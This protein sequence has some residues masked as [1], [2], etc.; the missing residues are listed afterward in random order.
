MSL[1]R[2]ARTN[3]VEEARRTLLQEIRFGRWPERL[4]GSRVLARQIGVSQPTVV[5]A[6]H[7]L[8][9]AGFIERSGE[10]RAFRVAV[11]DGNGSGFPHPDGHLGHLAEER[12][13]LLVTPMPMSEIPYSTREVFDRVRNRLHSRGWTVESRVLEF[14]GASSVHKSWDERLRAPKGVRMIAAYGT[15]QLAKWAATHERPVMFLGGDEGGFGVPVIAVRS[16]KMV[17]RA[18]A[19]LLEV[20]HSD[21]V[22]PM[23]GRRDSM[24]KAIR[25]VVAEKMN[26]RGIDFDSDFHTPCRDREEPGTIFSILARAFQSSRRPTALICLDWREAVACMSFLASHRLRVPDDVSMVLLNDQ[27]DAEWMVPRLSRF[28]FPITLMANRCVSWIEGRRMPTGL[29]ALAAGFDPGDSIAPPS[30]ARAGSGEEGVRLTA[31]GA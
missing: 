3:L 21:I 26:R 16:S 13:T 27:V 14:T 15:A 29:T 31:C 20:G 2:V 12:L 23:L 18:M 24:I 19:A 10:R 6:L 5:A 30:G 4:P 17:Q 22:I 1:S 9:E 7:R 8:A 25:E 11:G 28:R